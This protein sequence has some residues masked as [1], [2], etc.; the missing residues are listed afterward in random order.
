MAVSSGQAR[1]LLVPGLGNSGPGHWQSLWEARGGY[2]RVQQRD[3]EYPVLS[4]WIESLDRAVRDA[5]ADVLIAAHSLGALLVGH[6]LARTKV[7]IGGALLVA[8]PD[9]EAP[10]FPPQARGFAPIARE[11]FDCPSILVASSDDPYGDL[12]F[13]RQCAKSWGSRLVNIGEAGHINAASGVGE[14]S[15]GHRLLE[16]LREE[17]G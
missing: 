2:L 4:D 7:R 6:W 12:T 5:A 14:W 3:W 13:A 17:T 9:P 11:R 16:S 15:E 1:V 10:S 8:A